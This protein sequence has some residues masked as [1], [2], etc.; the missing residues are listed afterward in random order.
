MKKKGTILLIIMM[1]FS[2]LGCSNLKII[3][4]D[5]G[6]DD[7]KATINKISL[8]KNEYTGYTVVEAKVKLTGNNDKGIVAV[9]GLY[10]FLDADDN[11]TSTA[12]FYYIRANKPIEKGE[13]IIVEDGFQSKIEGDVKKVYIEITEVSDIDELPPKH[14]PEV[15]EKLYQ[16]LNSENINNIKENLPTKVVY[17]YD[18]MGF[19]T[20]YT[21][22]DPESI[23]KVVNAFSDITIKDETQT[24]ATDS[25]NSISFSFGE[26]EAYVSLMHAVLEVNVYNDLHYYELNGLGEF[27]KL[28]SEL[29]VKTTD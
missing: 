23:Q 20:Y 11:E 18:Q 10:H 27:T 17:T 15:G 13:T 8:K 7:I 28:M 19:R 16:A 14:L 2:L 21:V 5:V 9:H 1:L 12:R 24:V 22:E 26:K 25:Y 4:K 29:G 6:L 3:E